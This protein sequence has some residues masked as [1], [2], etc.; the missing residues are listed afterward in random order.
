M[1]AA[2]DAVL[3]T[4]GGSPEMDCW[5]AW[6]DDSQY[7]WTL[8]MPTPPGMLVLAVRP[9]GEDA[10]IV[11]KLVRWSRIQVGEFSVDQQGGHRVIGITIEGVVLRGA[12]EEAD[13]IGAFLQDIYAAVDGR[14][15]VPI[16][17]APAPAAARP[18]ATVGAKR[19]TARGSAQKPALPALPAVAAG[20]A[21]TSVGADDDLADD[22]L[23]DDELASF[24]PEEDRLP[25]LMSNSGTSRR[26]ADTWASTTPCS[27]SPPW[28]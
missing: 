25:S 5:T 13:R 20:P 17:A 4:M 7:K 9:G 12:D 1:V 11:G 3:Q 15:S 26:A 23:A 8:L 21:G 19:R 2:I 27:S 28:G 22:D 16:V 14:S 6:G 24:V 10:R 18:V